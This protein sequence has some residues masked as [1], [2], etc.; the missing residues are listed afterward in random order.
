MTRSAEIN[1]ETGET[2]IRFVLNVDG[3]G[4]SDIK[5]G[6]GF[7]DHMLETLARHSKMDM[8]VRAEGDLRVDEHHT[9]EDVGIC[10]GEALKKALGD[11]RGVTRFG[12]AFCPMD[13]ALARA[14]LDLSGRGFFTGDVP[15]ASLRIGG[16][17]G[18]VLLEFFKAAAL[19][20][21]I[22]LH[23]DMVRGENGHHI[24]EAAFKSFARALCMA[25]A[26]TD[27]AGIPSTKGTL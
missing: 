24:A 2:K 9:V 19:S 26:R 14:S 8:D 4:R 22:T 12:W 21:G 3:T 13:E 10:F 11:K 5:T 15:L 16:M 1:R 18:H 20:G 25:S 23:L 7:F 6:I 17:D 27:G